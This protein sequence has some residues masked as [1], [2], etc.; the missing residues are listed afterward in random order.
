M[1]RNGLQFW[2]IIV[3]LLVVLLLFGSNRLPDVARSVGKSMKILKEEV[4][5]LRDEPASAPT[6][7]PTPGAAAA[8]ATPPSPAPT[9][10]PADAAAPGGAPTDPLGGSGPADR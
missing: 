4:K 2:H 5:D 8:P 7:T 9:A 3:L 6:P 1:F 10:P